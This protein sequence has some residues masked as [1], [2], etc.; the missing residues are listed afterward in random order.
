MLISLTVMINEFL[1]WTAIFF[2]KF[3]HYLMC[4][5]FLLKNFFVENMMACL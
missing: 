3:S 2:L 5:I 4:M 1:N